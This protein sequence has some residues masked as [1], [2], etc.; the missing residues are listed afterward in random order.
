MNVLISGGFGFIGS[1]MV[2]DFLSRGL[3]V[4]V[5]T[6]RTPE[7]LA[8][9]RDR[10]TVLESDITHK[11]S[12]Q[13]DDSYDVF[14]HLAAANDV[15]SKKTSTALETTTLGTK[16]CL[17]FCVR[18]GVDKFIYFSTF[19][20]YG[21][22]S[23][24]I[25]ESSP[26]NCRNDYA[27]T[28]LFAEQ[29]VRMYER[30]F[31]LDFIIVRPTNVYGGIRHKDVDRWSLAPSC[32]CLEAFE[33]HTITLRSSGK[34]LRDFISLRDVSGMAALLCESFSKARNTTFNLARGKS[35]SILETAELVKATYER[36]FGKACKL[37]VESEEPSETEEFRVSTEKIRESGY[38]HDENYDLAGAVEETFAMLKEMG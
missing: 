27:I 29:Y 31:G 37:I 23:G 18:N 7:Y 32:F 25:D 2:E 15:D 12:V 5:L 34:Q 3:K 19:Q 10:V 9:L 30:N 4:G 22:D 16:H 13:P 14:I 6:R 8:S 24:Y 26:L 35:M 11:I 33:E 38:G 1:Y 17:D 20:V 21:A 28:H 36:L